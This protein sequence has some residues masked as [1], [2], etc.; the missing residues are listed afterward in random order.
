MIFDIFFFKNSTGTRETGISKVNHEPFISNRI[1]GENKT[2]RSCIDKKNGLCIHDIK[3]KSCDVCI[4]IQNRNRNTTPYCDHFKK[5]TEC[6]ECKKLGKGGGSLCDHLK[7]KHRCKECRIYREYKERIKNHMNDVHHDLFLYIW[8]DKIKH[9]NTDIL[10]SPDLGFYKNFVSD[11]TK[12]I[13]L[14]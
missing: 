4:N 14:F 5:R 13:M 1:K 7:Q 12:D 10:Y 2:C 3:K 8:K 6:K 11:T 9:I